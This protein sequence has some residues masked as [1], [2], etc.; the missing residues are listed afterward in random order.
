M[1]ECYYCFVFVVA[2]VLCPTTE[3]GAADANHVIMSMREKTGG[4]SSSDVGSRSSVGPSPAVS[5]GSF[6][7]SGPSVAAGSAV[8]SNTTKG[9]SP[10]VGCNSAVG[11]GSDVY[12]SSLLYTTSE[13]DVTQLRFLCIA[14]SSHTKVRLG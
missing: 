13:C 2:Y 11:R 7:G 10:V 1:Y 4:D 5:Y 3:G 6:V 9:S 12:S 14:T 8:G